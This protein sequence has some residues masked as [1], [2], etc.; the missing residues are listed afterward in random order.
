MERH[1][2]KRED[3]FAGLFHRLNVL[4]EPPRRTVR[5]KLT[6][7]G[8]KNRHSDSAYR[9]DTIN[10]VDPSSV[11]HIGTQVASADTDNVT[12]PHD[13]AAGHS[14]HANVSKPITVTK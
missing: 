10:I 11:A 5:A 1:G 8:H 12:G 3:R 2:F 13:V 6:R 4:L 7:I 9:G 14:A